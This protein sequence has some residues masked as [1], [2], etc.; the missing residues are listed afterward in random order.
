[1]AIN[2]TLT[3]CK[4]SAGSGKTFTL[5]VEYIKLLL[6]NPYA[7]EGILAV[8]F[9]NKAT[10]EMKMRILSTLYALAAGLSDA[11]RYMEAL[12]KATGLAE[13]EIVHR[14]G[15]VLRLLLHNYH[16]FRVQTIDTFFQSVLRN[17]AKELQLS[18]N[19]RVGL[20]NEQVVDQAVDNII[21][22][23]AEDDKLKR[24]VMGYMEE[25]MAEDKR[26]DVVGQIK[27][28]GGNIFK[29]HFK[30]NRHELD[31]CFAD[32]AFFD[33]YKKEM[34][35]I[36]RNAEKL[37]E[38]YSQQAQ[39]ILS[40]HG[41]SYEDF[42]SG[43]RGVMGYFIKLADGRY[44]AVDIVN[45]TVQ[46]AIVDA[47]KWVAKKH[48]RREAVLEVVKSELLP[49]MESI[50][51]TRE[52]DATMVRSAKKTLQHLND[53]RLLRRIEDMA[54]TLNEASQRFMLSDTQSL[55]S[56]FIADDD[57]PFIFEKIGS[58]LEH[59]MI[60][61]FQD[62]STVQWRNFKT[63]LRECMS[64]GNSNLI[65]GDVK[66]SI[67]R[68]RS[69]DWK[70]LNS[71]ERQF[72][73]GEL[74]FQPK[75]TNFR[76]SRNVIEFN[77]AFFE[78]VAAVEVE[79]V[80]QFS[81]ERADELQK[82]YADV[83]QEVPEGRCLEGY[84]E[85][86]LL[87]KSELDTMNERVLAIIEELLDMGVEQRD[88]AILVRK[89]KV[90]PALAQCVEAEGRVR[91]VS[92][93]AFRLDAS[94]VLQAIISG[95][96]LLI[97]PN[98]T[99]TQELLQRLCGGE[100][101]QE[102]TERRNEL[103]SMTLYDMAEALLKVLFPGE[104]QAQT[105]A[106]GAYLTMFFDRLK[107][108]CN[109][110]IPVVEDFLEVWDEELCRETIETGE[111]NGVRVLTI[112]KSKGL[113]FKHV[114]VP[115]CN[116]QFNP[117]QGSLIWVK[118]T[119][120][121]FSQMPI[122]PLECVS[123]A[124]LKGTIYEED[125]YEEQVQKIVDNLNLLYVA[126]TRAGETLHVIGER[127]ARD[128][129]RS[130]SIMDAIAR[131]PK[132]VK[133]LP[134]VIE[135]LESNEEPLRL[136]YGD[137][138]FL[139]ERRSTAAASPQKTAEEHEH[140][141][142][143]VFTVTPTPITVSVRSMDNRVEYRQSND[144]RRFAEDAIDETD[145]QRMVR[146]GMVMHQLFASVRTLDD[147]EPMITRMEYDGTLYDEDMDREKLLTKLRSVFSNPQVKGWFSDRWRVFNECNIINKEGE[148][149]PDRVIT[150]GKET[151]VIDFKFG[152]E[153]RGYV[154]QV[155]NYM[156]LL[157]EMGMPGVK[158]YLWYVMRGKVVNVESPTPALP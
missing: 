93:E 152:S 96:R 118:P 54:H 100:I 158:G 11:R 14:S 16:F 132:V 40:N 112:H 10:E 82:A 84:V 50:E 101:P 23:V 37:Y 136:T 134:V 19:L 68:F 36:I 51:E 144:S 83:K 97:R 154:E 140:K 114:I 72:G 6:E 145:R 12:Q 17:L 1:M 147:V 27:T 31:S 157:R 2:K 117:P 149:R 57:S 125:G 105:D 87:P 110:T 153:H 156:R 33:N 46:G 143:N 115:Y 52:H 138:D 150:D 103:L 128:G 55:L 92:D 44:A 88:I 146:M 39:Q 7:Y 79:N 59:V 85:V 73:K 56:D 18:A 60:D 142:K 107:D 104:R 21:D 71:I 15:K 42:S 113:E 70:L 58:R 69:G 108:F 78:H 106:E 90:I 49:L 29:E 5:A 66:Q 124:S 121:P 26:W 63:L 38:N 102:F 137:M 135:G 99:L 8:T 129:N 148:Q 141:Q 80:R 34:Y 131:L 119:V 123:A 43:N 3:V 86:E 32:E 89:N 126:L 28:F 47:E 65:V 94:K 20:N 133:E 13:E 67:Y 35:G 48:P 41:L 22:T 109:E 45:K 62:T 127:N 116:W 111:S 120:A 122:V 91:I 30:Q 151:I 61:E 139:T 75:R 25:K 64:Q 53:M 76:S 77:N 98:D 9:T 74:D 130:K 155:E 81:D 4:A 24:I 95:M